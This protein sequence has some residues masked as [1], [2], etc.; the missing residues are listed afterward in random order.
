MITMIENLKDNL[1]KIIKGDVEDSALAISEYSHD[2]SLFEVKPQVVVFPK[3]AEDIE[4]L[5]KFVNEHKKDDPNLSLTGRSAGTDMSG[6]PL[7]SSIIVSFGRY[8]TK[9]GEV[10]NDSVQSQPGVFYRD[11]EK[12][13]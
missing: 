7:N 9:I 5:V 2:A 12:E 10:K 13:T 6:G 4:N 11:L 8:F 1:K 3:D